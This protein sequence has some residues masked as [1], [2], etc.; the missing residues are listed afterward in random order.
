MV[1]SWEHITI[2]GHFITNG[3]RWE[4]PGNFGWEILDK[5]RF[6]VGKIH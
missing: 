6:M 2:N 1:I 5:S 3:T 4:I